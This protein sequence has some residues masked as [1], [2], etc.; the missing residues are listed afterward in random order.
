MIN[1]G[2]SGEKNRES[3]EILKREFAEDMINNDIFTHCKT[4]SEKQHYLGYMTRKLLDCVLGYREPDNRDSYMNT[5]IETTGVLLNT[6]LRN[7]FNKVVKD[8]FVYFKFIIK[9]SS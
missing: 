2:V 3:G 9:F 1:N 6:L 5:R 7:H 4:L 8:A